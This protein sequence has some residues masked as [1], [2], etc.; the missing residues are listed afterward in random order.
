MGEGDMPMWNPRITLSLAAAVAAGA[1]TT[2]MA[3]RTSPLPPPPPSGAGLASG[4]CFRSHDIK[5]HT[6][7]DDKTLL[8]RVN[9]GDVYRLTMAGNCLAGAIPSDPIVTR[10]PPGSSIVCKP[11]DIDLSIGRHGFT[12]RCIVDSIAKVAPDQLATL[13]PRLKP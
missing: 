9:R 13:P 6:I 7:A 3:G 11:I 8:V 10:E 12:T 5:N 2:A 4:Q 1:C